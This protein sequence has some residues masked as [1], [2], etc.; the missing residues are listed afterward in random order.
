MLDM[1]K[2]IMMIG[3]SLCFATA[4]AGAADHHGGAVNLSDMRARR[5]VTG[6]AKTVRIYNTRHTH[7]HNYNIVISI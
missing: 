2:N 4:A 3:I 7:I 6:V 5:S 1:Y